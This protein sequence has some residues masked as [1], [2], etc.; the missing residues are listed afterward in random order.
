MLDN[1]QLENRRVLLV[2]DLPSIHDD[3]RKILVATGGDAGLDDE[4][5]LLFG[6][7][8]RATVEFELDSAYQGAEALDKLANSLRAGLP[9][10]LAFV[11][12]RMPP[13]LDGVE[14]IERLWG[15]DSSLQVVICTAYT[16][17][18][19]DEVFRRLDAQDRLLVLKK[20]F[21]PVEVAQLARSLTVK[22]NLRVKAEMKVAELD[23][24]V[25]ERTTSLVQANE[26]LLS[27]IAERAR[28]EKQLVQSEK[29]ASIGQ[30]AAGVAHE[31]NTPIQYITDNVK[32]VRRTLDPLIAAAEYVERM[33]AVHCANQ[34]T[35]TSVG[36][37]GALIKLL[38][39]PYL[40]K[41]MPAAL[42]Q[43]LDG[44]RR[45]AGIVGA[46]KNFSHPTTD[47]AE[48]AEI[49]E[50]IENAVAI[51][52]SE[53]QDVADLDVVVQPNLPPLPCHRDEIGQV[54]LNLIVNA[55][56]AIGDVMSTAGT[57]RRGRIEIAAEQSGDF[58]QLSVK[59][60]GTGIPVDARSRVF[61]PFFTTKAV[62]RGTGQG[63]SISYAI[64]VQHHGG[65]IFFDTV[66]GQGTTFHVRL[67]YALKG[68]DQQRPIP[69]LSCA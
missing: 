22:W 6:T 35:D 5:A 21:D 26:A 53:W 51:G 12:M 8:K 41:N 58:L 25:K 59:D 66:D 37:A 13:G 46:M 15:I 62:G 24:A 33:V 55:A 9:Y 20:P 47:A 69:V 31:L 42:D 60:N 1:C 61:D 54:I 29:L 63:L 45:M 14:T 16:D 36:E 19:W 57:A 50:I 34:P 7:S 23:A 56:H 4:E 67:P 18:A 40:K 28:L 3:Y 43:S 10:A 48:P 32:F 38:K 65:E 44:L 68:A 17:Y 2:D 11:D 30:L 49:V 27:E 52:R 64:V 39:L